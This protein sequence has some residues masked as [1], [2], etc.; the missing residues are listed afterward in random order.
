[1]YLNP[2]ASHDVRQ[3]MVPHA[4][5]EVDDPVPVPRVAPG[6]RSGVPP[7]PMPP[8][9]ARSTQ[10]GALALR[11][12]PADARILVDGEEW[13]TSPPED[14]LSIRLDEGRHHLEIQKAGFQTFAGDIDVRA[15]ETSTLNV[16]LLS[17]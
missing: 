5:G 16:S 2:G 1:V 9:S 14:R 15:G 11:V 12:Q 17:E 4:A 10:Y 8:P 7:G 3:T 6:A 13:R